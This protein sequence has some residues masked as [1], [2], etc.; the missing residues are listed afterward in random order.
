MKRKPVVGISMKIYQNKITDAVNYATS[1]SNLEKT[2]KEI[3]LFLLPSLGTL[4]PVSKALL[5]SRSPIKFGA[6]NI[7]QIK[8]GAMT[9]EF[10]LETLVD[11]QGRFVELGHYERRTFLHESDKAINAKMQL[12]VQNNLVPILCIGEPEKTS[13]EVLEKE[14]T[15]IL[16]LDL[17]N[18]DP[19][20]LSNMIIAYEPYWAIGKKESADAEYISN[21]HHIIRKVLQSIIGDLAQNI[22]IIYGGSVSKDSAKSI[23]SSKDVDGVFVG[24]FGHDPNNFKKIVEEV[25]KNYC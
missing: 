7:A 17:A 12:T 8:N 18:I 23:T 11:M 25:K 16:N 13:S 4:Y 1:V 5:D 22:R 10:S 20:M 2:E 15:D 19:P 6:Q 9:G 21:V 24:R 3:D 14:F